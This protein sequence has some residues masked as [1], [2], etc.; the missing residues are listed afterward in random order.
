V[1][2]SAATTDPFTPETLF[3]L[4]RDKILEGDAIPPRPTDSGIAHLALAPNI[5]RHE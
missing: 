2:G 1:K 3:A 5:I 4:L